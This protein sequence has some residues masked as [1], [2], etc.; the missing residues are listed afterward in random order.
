MGGRSRWGGGDARYHRC[1]P[2]LVSTT[3]TAVTL[4][5]TVPKGAVAH[6]SHG[7]VEEEGG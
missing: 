4:G 2:R 5:L 3:A 6:H 7:E 1:C